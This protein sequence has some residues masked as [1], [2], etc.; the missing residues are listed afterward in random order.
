M[1][2]NLMETGRMDG[3]FDGQTGVFD[4]ALPDDPAYRDAYGLAHAVATAQRERVNARL[5]AEYE[6]A[7]RSGAYQRAV[8]GGGPPAKAL[9]PP[10]VVSDDR[11]VLTQAE[12]DEVVSYNAGWEDARERQEPSPDSHPD[13]EAYDEG[14]HQSR[15]D[16]ATANRDKDDDPGV[17]RVRLFRQRL[18][19]GMTLEQAKAADVADEKGRWGSGVYGCGYGDPWAETLEEV[20]GRVLGD[21]WWEQVCAEQEAREAKVPTTQCGPSRKGGRQ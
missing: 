2:Q 11:Q 18:L 17:E 15:D 5:T 10:E 9:Y 7:R 8:A 3:R 1:K 19:R 4:P 20:F 14:Y 13:P 21:G 16:I 6:A 12:Q